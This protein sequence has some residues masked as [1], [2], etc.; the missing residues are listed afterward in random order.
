MWKSGIFEIEDINEALLEEI[1]FFDISYPG[2]GEPGCCLW[3]NKNTQRSRL[4]VQS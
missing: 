3:H 1:V 2:M 4:K